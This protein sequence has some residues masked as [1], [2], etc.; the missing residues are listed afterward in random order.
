[1]RGTTLIWH[2]ALPPWAQAKLASGRADQAEWLMREWI[3]A[4][5]RRYAG[6]I[7][8]WDVVNEI[9]G[10]GDARPDGLRVTPWL[11]ALGPG[12]IDLAFET[13]KSVDP[14]AAPLWNENDC[15]QDAPW[16]ETRRTLILRTLEGLKRRGVPITRF[17]IQGHLLT[18]IPLDQKRLRAFLAEIAAMGLAIEI[19]ELDIDDRAFPADIAARDRGVADLGRRFLDV[20][21]DEPAVLNVLNWDVY[22][23]DTWLNASED[24]RRP[25]GLPQRAL[26]Y[27]ADYA[28][29]PLW[30]AMH[31]A[32][33]DAPDHGAARA[34]L[35]RG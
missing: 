17:G 21:L 32:F 30:Q 7:E 29:K 20:V 12:Y 11:K 10:Y 23:P 31:R 5:A 18:T 22:D 9:V 8:S 6:A 16:I 19:T 33:V 25:D 34:R 3:G 2:E 26:P 14:A 27:D 24:R 1:M 35:R 15:E 13:L 28:R 4:V